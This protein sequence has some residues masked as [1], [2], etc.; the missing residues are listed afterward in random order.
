MSLNTLPLQPKVC[1]EEGFFV[2]L[3]RVEGGQIL[4]GSSISALSLNS[5]LRSS[6]RSH[7]ARRKKTNRARWRVSELIHTVGMKISDH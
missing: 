5:I 3:D 1:T 2:L 7:W 4:D 6:P